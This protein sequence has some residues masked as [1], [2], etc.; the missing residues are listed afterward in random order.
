MSNY[1][2]KHDSGRV[3]RTPGTKKKA[4]VFWIG[5]AVY[6]LVL[7]GLAAWFL[8]YTDRCLQQYEA[9]Q[10]DNVMQ[11]FMAQLS[12]AV[13][14]GTAGELATV[15]EQITRFGQE[16][17]YRALCVQRLKEA[18]ALTFRRTPGNYSTEAPMYDLLDGDRVAAQMKLTAT[19]EQTI[20]AILTILDWKI[21][22]ITVP[23]DDVLTEYTVWAPA[24]STPALNGAPMGERE[25]TGKDFDDPDLANLKEYAAVPV[26]QQYKIKGLLPGAELTVTDGAGQQLPTTDRDGE[27]WAAYTADVGP[28][29]DELRETAVT[30]AKTWDDFLTNDLKGPK[31]GVAQLQQYL[32][33]DSMFWDMAYAYATGIDI[34]F[35]SAH[36]T[37]RN[38]YSEIVVDDYVRY[39]EDSFRCHI[40]F[41]KTMHLTDGGQR[42]NNTID[43][44]FYF[45]KHEGKWAMA[46]MRGA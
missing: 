32:I 15:P 42:V 6:A 5:L 23:V 25:L 37:S 29:S 12:A 24:G 18:G 27:P 14:D 39:S 11:D 36:E 22:S 16:G 45:V 30:I 38:R 21:D 2:A 26:L 7:V 10:P 28:I 34:T 35:T 17:E 33:P 9:A 46:D 43:S 40:S 19:G 4:P 20:F 13:E 1:T 3:I 44:V 31:H 8:S 41:T